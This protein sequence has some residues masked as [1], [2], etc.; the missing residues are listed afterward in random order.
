MTDAEPSA[1][2]QPG[3]AWPGRRAGGLLLHDRHGAGA[4]EA[5]D[6]VSG[7]HVLAGE[8]DPP[9]HGGSGGGQQPEVHIEEAAIRQLGEGCRVDVDG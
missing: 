1:R 2:G 3:L 4:A 8:G 5:A 9:A 7:G 6:P